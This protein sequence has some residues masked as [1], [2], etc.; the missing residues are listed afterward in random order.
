MNLFFKVVIL[1]LL[2]FFALFTIGI[3]IGERCYE[4]GSCK[5]CWSFYDEKTQ[6]NSLIDLIT[7]GCREAKKKDFQDNDI[8]YK[9]EMIYE[10][11][12]QNKNKATAMQICTGEIPLVK[13][14]YQ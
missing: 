3:F 13:Y 6:Y 4:I 12:T 10:S 11:L 1:I 9:I 8:N 2:S 5:E 14:E 7:C